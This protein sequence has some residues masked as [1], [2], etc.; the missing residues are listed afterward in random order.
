[1]KVI[2]DGLIFALQRQGGIS[3]YWKEL[4]ERMLNDSIDVELTL[5]NGLNNPNQIELEQS[6]V[7][8]QKIKKRKLVLPVWMCRFLPFFRINSKVIFHSS[9]LNVLLSSKSINI[10]TIHDLGYERN[11]TQQGLK[12]IINLFFKYFALHRANGF[13]CISEFTKKEFLLF[14][15]HCAEKKIKVIYNGV[16]DCFF[17]L[18]IGTMPLFRKSK[19]YILFVGARYKYKRFKFLIYALEKLKNYS[20]II[21]GGGNLSESELILLNKKLK[22]RF[23]HYPDASKQELNNLYNFAHCLVYPST[24]EGFGIPLV[25]AM[26]AGCP[27]I[28][29]DIPSITEVVDNAGILLALNSTES[30]LSEAI[31]TLNI[32]ENRNHL[33]EN[34]ERV[35]NKYSWDV[36]F[37]QTK[38]FYLELSNKDLAKKY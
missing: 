25:E 5:Y 28:A 12:R 30:E 4:S 6:L 23:F 18:P 22:G 35:S 19:P 7:D 26:R 33:I 8:T 3:V 27:F 15:P 16:S 14:Y 31:Q 11:L 32:I 17:R 34:G 29:Y 37:L 13:I 36:C 38:E 10:L 1:M 20:L 2:L 21:V 24:Y 9:Y